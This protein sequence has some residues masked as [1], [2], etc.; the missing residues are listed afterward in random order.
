MGL[1]LSD[2]QSWRK[3]SIATKICTTYYNIEHQTS[4][5][6]ISRLN[7]RTV[8][9]GFS[10]EINRCCV[11]YNYSVVKYQAAKIA[12]FKTNLDT[13]SAGFC[14]CYMASFYWENE[15]YVAHIARESD[16]TTTKAEWNNLVLNNNISRVHLF[17]PSIQPPKRV[18]LWGLI[19][20][21][22]KGYSVDISENVL[23]NRELHRLQFSKVPL[24]YPKVYTLEEISGGIIP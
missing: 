4:A 16:F 22:D 10:N 12:V 24:G 5:Q 2:L 7:I 14:G 19:T 9:C 23:N 17:K 18:G 15:R 20:N 8:I 13:L 3:N 1:L 11:T 6:A 21:D